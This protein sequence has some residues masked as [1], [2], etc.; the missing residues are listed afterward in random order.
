LNKIAV[1]SSNKPPNVEFNRIQSFDLSA[2]AIAE[3][4][5]NNNSVFN[6]KLIDEEV[7]IRGNLVKIKNLVNKS[8]VE[9]ERVNLKNFELLNK[10]FARSE[11]LRSLKENLLQNEI[12]LNE[13]KLLVDNSRQLTRQN[14]NLILEL[15]QV[16]RIS[17]EK[18][19]LIRSLF[20]LLK[21]NLQINLKLKIELCKKSIILCERLYDV[22]SRALK[23]ITLFRASLSKLTNNIKL[24]EEGL[25]TAHIKLIIVKEKLKTIRA[26]QEY[27]DLNIH[28]S[29]TNTK[30]EENKLK[31]IIESILNKKSFKKLN[32]SL[33]TNNK[34]ESFKSFTNN[35]VQIT[36][37]IQSKIPK[38][39]SKLIDLNAYNNK[40]KEVN[41]DSKKTTAIQKELVK[42]EQ[43]EQVINKS[44]FEK[45]KFET[46]IKLKIENAVNSA[47]LQLGKEWEIG[48]NSENEYTLEE[49]LNLLHGLGDNIQ[50][51]FIEKSN[52][53]RNDYQQKIQIKIKGKEEELIAMNKSH[54]LAKKN[55]IM[56][57]DK[58]IKL[59][60][61][62]IKSR[63]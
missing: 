11:V 9:D 59:Y 55:L 23:N 6:A 32:E 19:E 18:H 22:K 54:E 42:T 49:L 5:V 16:W 36:D 31:S 1:P 24:I 25:S 44:K 51:Q 8:I 30:K 29:I 52:Q 63:E 41:L 35:L 57:Y 45:E 53:I 46:E 27:S 56:E 48:Y 28:D 60:E 47:K 14:F 62:I 43:L 2:K 21:D 12:K 13:V 34:I 17:K 38:L 10:Y 3:G 40:F 37:N 61:D 33:N 4:E 39:E 50:A 20:W 58:E 15:I 26:I 7:D